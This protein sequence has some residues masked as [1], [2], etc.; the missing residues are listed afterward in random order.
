MK[1]AVLGTGVLAAAGIAIALVASF[2]SSFG[3]GGTPLEAAWREVPESTAGAHAETGAPRHPGA[4]TGAVTDAAASEESSRVAVEQAVSRE[5][6]QQQW[7]ARTRIVGL[8]QEDFRPT[9]A[10]SGTV[11]GPFGEPMAGVRV[12][13]GVGTGAGSTLSAR[14]C[15]ER[16]AR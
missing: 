15:V 13:V 16:P 7:T 2:A 8:S 5:L 10:V 14:L 3:G 4:K 9:G 6:L 11:M 12:R 1:R